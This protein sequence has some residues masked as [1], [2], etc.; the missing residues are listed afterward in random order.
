MKN[1]IKLYHYSDKDINKIKPSCFGDNGYTFND[2]KASQVKKAFYYI[3]NSQVEYRFKD[4]RY[5]YIMKMW[6]RHT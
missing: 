5:R 2:R 1:K 4:C 3:G 6:F